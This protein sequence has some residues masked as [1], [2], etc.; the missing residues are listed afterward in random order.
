MT[1]KLQFQINISGDLKRMFK[2]VAESTSK[3]ERDKNMD[4]IQELIT[5]VQFAND[6]C[7]YG[8]GLELGMDL[9]TYGG[10]VFHSMIDCL[11][12][13][14]YQLL[15]RNEYAKIIK[16]HLKHRVKGVNDELEV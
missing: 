5:L 15:R 13:L 12:P 1:G 8:E 3:T 9:F 11:L 6:E 10:E 4:D 2:K 16:A 7:D 14:A